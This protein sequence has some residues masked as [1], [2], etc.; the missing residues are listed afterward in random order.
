MHTRN[1]VGTWDITRVPT[2]PEHMLRLIFR[3]LPCGSDDPSRLSSHLSPPQ[4]RVNLVL[5]V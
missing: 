2:Y 3:D 4:Y 1:Q 5:G